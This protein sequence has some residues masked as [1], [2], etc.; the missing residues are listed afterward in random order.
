MKVTLKIRITKQY[1]L[2]IKIVYSKIKE[3]FVSL[4]ED[5]EEIDPCICFNGNFITIGKENDKTIHFIKQWIENPNE[6]P[7]YSV[8]FQGKEYQLLAEVL[9]AI[10]INEFKQRIEREYIFQKTIVEIPSKIKTIKQRIKISLDALGLR[11]MEL[12]EED[13]IAIDYTKQGEY[14]EEILEKKELIEKQ[15]RMI[16]RAKEINPT[17]KDKLNEI[18]LNNENIL[19]EDNFELELSKKFTTKERTEMKLCQLD[20]YCIFI[21]SRYFNS[22]DVH[23]ISARR[24]QGSV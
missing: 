20:N 12:E 15:K 18:N 19:E 5:N 23:S 17:M 3:K 11:G 2:Q 21:T 6:F 14:L 4:S 16:E 24:A 13:D 9:F 8:M 7:L 22:L 1:K 10:I